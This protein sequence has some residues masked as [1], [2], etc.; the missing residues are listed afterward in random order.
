MVL[1]YIFQSKYQ[2]NTKEDMV[3]M[4]KG[5]LRKRI[6]IYILGVAMALTSVDAGV[7]MAAPETKNSS[8]IVGTKAGINVESDTSVINDVDAADETGSMD[9]VEN[10]DITDETGSTDGA[11]T[12]GETG[13]TDGADT[14][15][16]ADTADGTDD[17][18]KTGSTDGADTTDETGSTDGTDTTD[19]ADTTDGTGTTDETGG[20]DG[21]DLTGET[22]STDTADGTENADAAGNIDGTE[23]T[24]G[25]DP[26]DSAEPDTE[27]SDIPEPGEIE[28]PGETDDIEPAIEG[29]L[30]LD[31]EESAE[32]AENLDEAEIVE[33]EENS[34]YP[35]YNIIYE[36]DSTS[37]WTRLET[38]LEDGTFNGCYLGWESKDSFVGWVYKSRNIVNRNGTVIADMYEEDFDKNKDAVYYVQNRYVGGYYEYLPYG[39]D[40]NP[41][42][43]GTPMWIRPTG[44]YTVPT[45]CTEEDL[46][47][48]VWNLLHENETGGDEAE[49]TERKY[50]I[51][52]DK[53]KGAL[54]LKIMVPIQGR[55][56]VPYR[57]YM[58]HRQDY[59]YNC[60]GYRAYESRQKVYDQYGALIC[61]VDGYLNRDV[62]YYVLDHETDSGYS[63]EPYDVDGNLMEERSNLFYSKG[64][65]YGNLNSSADKSYQKLLEIS[66]YG[67]PSWQRG[68]YGS[69]VP[70]AY[71][72]IT[73]TN[74]DYMLAM[75]LYEQFAGQMLAENPY[76]LP[77]SYKE[78]Y[79]GDVTVR[80]TEDWY[81]ENKTRLEAEAAEIVR[82]EDELVK[83]N[84]ID[85]NDPNIKVSAIKAKTYTG[86]VLE[87]AIKITAKQGKKKKKLV[88][89]TDYTISYE[90]NIN[91]GTAK[92]I[93]TGMGAYRETITR[94]FTIKPKAVSKTKAVV[95][96]LA[97]TNASAVDAVNL[98][99]GIRRL[100][101]GTDYTLAQVTGIQIGKT[102]K[103]KV[104]GIGNYKGTKTVK[105]K[106]YSPEQEMT[107]TPG[108]VTLPEE[109]PS[110]TGKAIKIEPIV[111][112]DG[113][114]L[115]K[116]KNYKLSYKNNV[117]AGT[118]FVTVQ[119]KG[120][121]KG[122]VV[123]SFEIAPE[124][125]ELYVLCD[126][127]DQGA[128][129]KTY[130][131]K[132]IRPSVAVKIRY[133][134][135][136]GRLTRSK[137]LKKG[138]D[139]RVTYVNNLHVGDARV[140]VTGIGNYAGNTTKVDFTIMPQNI[141][142]VKVSGTQA[143]GLTVTYGARTL[144]EN[145]DYTLEY[146][147][148][149]DGKV[150]VKIRA[151]PGRDFTGSA[152][153]TVS[154]E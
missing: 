4:K 77:D 40:K 19:G 52:N 89:G 34:D 125:A 65:V 55:N 81:E 9:G 101:E 115:I 97:V 8:T 112:V 57:T 88:E 87:P 153:R 121:Y 150:K 102:V 20:M 106:G 70:T 135:D 22:G 23:N 120:K 104:T 145:V 138:R 91:A 3:M 122:K 139:Y 141:T 131:G 17:T 56:G 54:Y 109:I 124:Q 93:I 94:E 132:L 129:F 61:E 86:S 12:T 90:D 73:G 64:S 25:T 63:Y 133:F 78:D 44:T 69:L 95:Q 42:N 80:L 68:A 7:V 140:I 26:S 142:E 21:T 99:D 119:G 134:D 116:N 146:S 149:K 128:L 15:G 33:L 110:Y 118:A 41:L 18:D 117:N 35:V 148:V 66:P 107:I 32:D 2:I 154:V 60:F 126:N 151:V 152:T 51:V 75:S 79:E 58:L 38:T 74:S 76:V 37:R 96:N 50:E 59:V 24:D 98:Y 49:I 62:A 92:V 123:K 1:A 5:L 83:K 137:K 85:L 31:S 45:A 147:T 144:I 46:P 6:L 39:I 136:R 111:T 14:T 114:V 47:D 29:E 10:A 27:D 30:P 72:R 105:V 100:T 43:D 143:A 127:Y 71:K 13:S 16:G 48:R 84:S 53:E 67:E 82:M 113:Q 130:N 108:C 36:I 103:V 28:E 11:D